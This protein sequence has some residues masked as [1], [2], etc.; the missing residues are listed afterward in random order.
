M[1]NILLVTISKI[2][3]HLPGES[4]LKFGSLLGTFAWFFLPKRKKKMMEQNICETLCMSS[5]QAHAISKASFVRFGCM[6]V[7]FLQYPSFSEKNIARSVT[8]EGLEHLNAALAEKKGAVMVAGHC[9]NWEL[10]GAALAYKGFPMVAV[11]KRQKNNKFERFLNMYRSMPSKGIVLYKE[12]LRKVIRMLRGNKIPLIFIDIDGKDTGVFIKF[13][14]RR[15][16]TPPGAAILAQMCSCP[17][18]PAF[19]KQDSRGIHHI[20]ICE[21]LWLEKREDTDT[22]VYDMMQHISFLLENRIRNFPEDWFW[23]YNRWKTKNRK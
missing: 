20:K 11:T 2:L 1:V 5:E 8:F 4:K 21:P 16:S 19:I 13:L 10:L 18:I 14:G 23:L 15:T 7:D 3:F 17:I 12:E 6:L 9:G 22:A